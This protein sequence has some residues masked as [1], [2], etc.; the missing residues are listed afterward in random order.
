MLYRY[1]R[2]DGS[3]E[4]DPLTADDA[5]DSLA[6]DLME[7]GDLRDALRRLLR[8]GLQTGDGQ[9]LPGLQDLID[10]LRRRRREELERYDLDSSMEEIERRLEDVVRTEREGIGRRLQQAGEPHLPDQESAQKLRETL[11]RIANQKLEK[12]D[13]LPPDP[14]GRI[15]AL[16][17]YDFMD[18]E[19]R[20]KFDELMRMLQQQMLGS[21]F[22]GLK[23][24]LQRLTPGDLQALREMVRDLN[25]MLEERLRGGNPDFQGFMDKHGQYFPGIGSLEEL[26]EHLQRR[27]GQMRSL[28]NSMSPEM[29]DSLQRIMDDLLQDDRLR[30]DMLR[31]AANLEQLSP[32][33]QLQARYPFSGEESLTMEEAMRLMERLQRMDELE[34]QLRHAEDVQ[35]LEGLDARSVGELLGPEAAADLDRL[36]RLAS[37][38]E[39]NGYLERK[40]DR[41]ELTA[42]AIRRIGQKAL[43]EIFGHLK[44]DAFGRHETDFAGRGGE[45]GEETKEYEFGDPFLVNLEETLMNS[46]VREGGGTPVRIR[47]EDFSVYRTEQTTESSIVLMLDMSRSMV[48]RGCFAAAKKVAL[49]LNSLIQGQFPGDRLY[50]VLFS[51]YARQVRPEQLAELTWDWEE[52]GTNLQHALMLGRHLLGRHKTG[53]RQILVITDGEPTAHLEGEVARFSYPPSPRTLVETLKEVGRCTRDGIVINTFMLER[54]RSL[55]E[56]V[57][58]VARINR[59]RAFFTPPERLGEYI[60]VDY[61]AGKRKRVA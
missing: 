4:V 33:R 19:A 10:R 14:A 5:M 34:R 9:R 25:R 48:M 22:E 45:R 36:R 28:L 39:E 59:G 2:W 38:L 29:R 43:R 55:V 21:M 24:S 13:R 57:D 30:W 1:Y 23:S 12:L 20:R 42:R 31:L 40:G 46:L 7:D 26:V 54:S 11:E 44:K 3:Q 6:D 58:R 47:P 50:I 37:L 8:T 27:S 51:E 49:A 60:L 32:G 17:E 35:G 56:F 61:V 15:K 18:Q 52:Y 41:Y 53:N 16:S